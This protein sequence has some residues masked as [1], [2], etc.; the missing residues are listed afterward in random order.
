M[1]RRSDSSKRRDRRGEGRRRR[2]RAQKKGYGSGGGWK[3]EKDTMPKDRG[4][5]WPEEEH[6]QGVAA[7]TLSVHGPPRPRVLVRREW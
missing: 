4:A 2:C 6:G 7:A 5:S 3:R 1:R